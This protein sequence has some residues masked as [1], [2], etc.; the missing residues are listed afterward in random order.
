MEALAEGLWGLADNHENKGEIG[1]AVKCLEAICQS[2]VSFL[3]IVEI[4]TRLRIATLLLKH[5]NNVNHAKSHLERSQLLLKSIPSCFELK[6]RAY[7]LLSQCYHLVG[8][9]PPQKQILNKGLEL[10]ASSGDGL[11][12]KLWSCNFNSQLANALIIEGDY[13]NSISALE[14]GYECATE[15]R[16]PELQMFF[17][18]SILHV[19]FMQW[20]DVNSV[21]RAVEKCDEVWECI[22]PDK[23]Q[24]CLGL[25]FYNELL[26]TF[27]RLRIC[28]YKNA[29]QHIDKLDAA[30]K[31]ELQQVQRVE[32]LTGELNAI[33]LSLSRS[34]LHHKERSALCQK[35]AQIEEQLSH[36][37]RFS[38][39]GKVSLEPSY[40]GN[41]R[42]AWED[43]LALAPPPIDG[44][45]LPKGAVYALVDLMV[46]ISGRPKGSYKECGRRI[47]SGLHAIH[48]ELLQLGITDGVTEVDLQ[49]SAIWMAGVYLMILMQFLENKVAMSL[50][51]AEFVEA[52]EALV[53]MKNWLVSF[54][55][56]LQGCES[57]FEILR[58]QYAHSLGCFSE[59]A[60]H[61][62]EAAK[63][64][65]SKSLQ[66]MCQVYAAVSYI[67][68]GDAESS[69][70]ALDLIGPVYR[71]MDSFDGVREKTAVLFAYGLLLMKQHNLQE[72]R[73]RLASGLR[74]THQHLGNIQLVS[75]YLTILGSLALAL[76]DT[77][78][79][80][81]ILK[82]SLTLAKS[83]YDI[84]T[85]I[86]VLSVLTALY[87]EL[88][89]R[90]NEMANSEYER[91]K[92]DDLQ[93]RLADAQSSIHHI[94]L[95]DKV[96]VNVRQNNEL[97]IKRAINAGSS[98]RFNLDI[99]ESVGL[100]APS[101]APSSS[102]LMD[103]DIRRRGKRRM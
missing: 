39:T 59:A 73:I 46:V 93:K 27:Y 40:F 66:A 33:N 64:T 67:C 18:T 82:S 16:Y 9:I 55:T 25:F 98:M 61:F 43:K 79:A 95:I 50:T 31:D 35:Q 80:R 97:D 60:F 91:K 15:I 53:Q 19:H 56:I 100:S 76:H 87:Q 89:E 44:E 22:N 99:P 94:E 75:Q 83:L 102:K 62:T 5:T 74:I 34:G 70:Q 69:S 68:I 23:R 71:I 11:A 8:A 4:K 57:I 41:A 6:C 36:V 30:M 12:V 10:T 17:A 32:E 26:H 88:G 86:W 13:R 21:E 45:W 28:D 85:Q 49:H 101:P 1:K 58:G 29:S 2:Q 81:E 20:D 7:S 52:Q 54:P 103:M 37:T 90:G 38:S 63:L 96:R 78:Q 3:P 51:R 77:G 72:A 92:A 84:P 65:E 24:Q 48:V 47:Q 42:R 14:R